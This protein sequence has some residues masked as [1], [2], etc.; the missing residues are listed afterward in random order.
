MIVTNPYMKH[1]ISLRHKI[2]L[3]L[4]KVL[5]KKKGKHYTAWKEKESRSM[6]K[7]LSLTTHTITRWYD[8]CGHITFLVMVKLSQRRIGTI[9]TICNNRIHHV[10]QS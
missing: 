9:G 1:E 4:T 6:V 5:K 3:E 7:H 2:I 8:G 10:Q